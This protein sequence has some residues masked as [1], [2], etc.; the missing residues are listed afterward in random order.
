MEMT[1]SIIRIA[2][3]PVFFLVVHLLCIHGAC[4]REPARCLVCPA[5]LL[6]GTPLEDDTAVT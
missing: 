3:G 6:F 1:G 5:R 4:P 2:D